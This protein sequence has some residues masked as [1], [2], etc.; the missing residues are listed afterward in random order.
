LEAPFIFQQGNILASYIEGATDV[1]GNVPLL[2]IEDSDE[3]EGEEG[4]E[5]EPAVAEDA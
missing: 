2:N 1:F 3:D 5:D 4:S